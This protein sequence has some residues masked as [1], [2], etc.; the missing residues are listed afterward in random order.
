MTVRLVPSIPPAPDVSDHDQIM[1]AL[2]QAMEDQ[3]RDGEEGISARGIAIIWLRE[4]P[5]GTI[6]ESFII[7]GMS[8]LEAA[9]LLHMT[10]EDVVNGAMTDAPAH[11]PKDG[12]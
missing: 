3:E 8:G 1:A 6:G 10:A 4:Y 2:T 9:G 7:Q 11:F 12:A 5:D